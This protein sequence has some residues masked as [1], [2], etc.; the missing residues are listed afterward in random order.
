MPKPTSS[1]QKQKPI[2]LVNPKWVEVTV[3]WTLRKDESGAL[4][5]LEKVRED[6]RRVAN[7]PDTAQGKAL[8]REL[9]N[10]HP[11]DYVLTDEYECASLSQLTPPLAEAAEPCTGE[12]RYRRLKARV[13]NTGDLV[14]VANLPAT[15]EGLSIFRQAIEKQ[16]VMRGED[17]TPVAGAFYDTAYGTHRLSDVEIASLME[18]NGLEA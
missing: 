8:L 6:R 3:R 15:R 5:A 1:D 11:T 2:R 17:G 14:D 4:G 9:F 10:C 7:I 16:S 12:A 18:L 13:G